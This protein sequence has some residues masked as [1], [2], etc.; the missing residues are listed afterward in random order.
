MIIFMIKVMF[1]GHRVVAPVTQ[2]NRQ[3]SDPTFNAFTNIITS[4][5]FMRTGSHWHS[6][7]AHHQPIGKLHE[8]FHALQ[9]SY[10][11]SFDKIIPI[12]VSHLD[13]YTHKCRVKDP[14]IQPASLLLFNS[15]SKKKKR[16]LLVA[17]S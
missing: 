14:P 3:R 16:H 8:Y 4:S 2:V 15:L 7:Y 10:L 17:F 6:L 5:R 11:C 9:T 13:K 12:Q 1:Q